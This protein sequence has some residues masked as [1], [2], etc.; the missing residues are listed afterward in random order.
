[1]LSM[2]AR[3]R[4]QEAASLAPWAVS[5]GMAASLVLVV[6]ARLRPLLE[7]TALLVASVAFVVAAVLVVSAYAMLR[8]RDLLATARRADLVLS[9]DERLSTALEDAQRDWPN[10]VNRSCYSRAIPRSDTL[11]SLPSVRRG[12]RWHLNQFHRTRPN[13]DRRIVQTQIVPIARN[14]GGLRSR[15]ATGRFHRQNQRF[16]QWYVRPGARLIGQVRT[17]WRNSVGAVF[18]N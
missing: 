13:Q 17:D 7:P 3:L 4:L 2:Q 9:L 18:E 12:K 8:P 11:T 10:P 5:L 14:F 1:M 6:A 15:C 16:N